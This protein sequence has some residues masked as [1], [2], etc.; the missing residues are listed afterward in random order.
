[1]STACQAINTIYLGCGVQ[2]INASSGLLF[3]PARAALSDSTN[4]CRAVCNNL[5]GQNVAKLPG[6]EDSYV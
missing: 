1:M 4:P 5:H 2:Q 6:C 3:G